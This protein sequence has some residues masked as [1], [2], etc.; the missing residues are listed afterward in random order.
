VIVENIMSEKKIDVDEL[1][2]LIGK[3]V[4]NDEKIIS[5]K[6]SAIAVSAIIRESSTDMNGF[7]YDEFG[8]SKPNT[9]RDRDIRSMLR[10]L[11]QAMVEK[12]GGEAWKACLIQIT[13]KDMSIKMDFEYEDENRWKVTPNNRMEIM[14]TMKP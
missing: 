9:P 2:H 10:H 12:N 14:E 7:M 3:A 5:V 1:M 4:V 8:N 11:K 6:W 13:K